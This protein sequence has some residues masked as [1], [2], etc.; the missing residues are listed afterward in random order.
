MAQK[1]FEY[2]NNPEAMQ[3][4][5]LANSDSLKEEFVESDWH[6]LKSLPSDIGS[7]FL[8]PKD[9]DR[10][11][12]YTAAAV[13]AIA[14]GLM[15]GDQKIIEAVQKATNHIDDSFWLNMKNLGGGK[16]I[17][18]ATGLAY[19]SATL[20]KNPRLKRASVVAFNSMITGGVLTEL[21]KNIAGRSRP[22]KGL[23]DR[24]F[25]PFGG[26]KSFPSGHI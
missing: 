1:D 19:L 20:M 10:K 13:S 4:G 6:V 17:L 21:L 9:W 26:S 16:L 3:F 14:A 12:W 25:H 5:H 11:E 23:G 24:D 7:A 18:P 2:R 22:N 8:A 15:A